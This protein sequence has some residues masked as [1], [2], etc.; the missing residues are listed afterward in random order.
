MTK[1]WVENKDYLAIEHTETD[2]G[3]TDNKNYCDI[4]VFDSVTKKKEKGRRNKLFLFLPPL[5]IIIKGARVAYSAC[6]HFQVFQG[7]LMFL[8]Y[9]WQSLFCVIYSQG[10]HFQLKKWAECQQIYLSTGNI[11]FDT[12]TN[13]CFT[14][15]DRWILN[16]IGKNESR[17]EVD[18]K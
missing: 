9:V 15:N 12:F 10:M 16:K 2:I 18:N 11:C 8:I 3:T 14:F 13:L 7:K 6:S 5:S 17:K 4:S 1:R